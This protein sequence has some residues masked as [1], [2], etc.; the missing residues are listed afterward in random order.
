MGIGPGLCGLPRTCR[1]TKRRRS[2]TAGS[3][4]PAPLPAP[5][6]SAAHRAL[7][8]VEPLHR[9]TV[10]RHEVV[11]GGEDGVVAAPTVDLV[12]PGAQLPAYAVEPVIAD[13]APEQV[14]PTAALHRVAAAFA[15]D[16]VVAGAAVEALGRR[17][18]L[19]A[20]V[21][22]PA[23]PEDEVITEAPADPVLAAPPESASPPPLP[24]IKS[25]VGVPT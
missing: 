5:A 2:P 24:S 6:R 25:L 9:L 11:D 8:R 12:A 16:T 18:Y 23:T 20:G 10:R 7:L 13:A 22:A 21:V 3:R 15:L 17:A 14:S 1:V 4:C 19:E